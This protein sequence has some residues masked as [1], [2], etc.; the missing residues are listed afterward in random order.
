MIWRADSYS[1]TVI[2]TPG[3]TRCRLVETTQL[4]GD[5]GWRWGRKRAVRFAAHM[6]DQRMLVSG[7]PSHRF[8]VQEM[9]WG[10][11]RIIALQNRLEPLPGED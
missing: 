1:G 10:R 8:A 7:A 4:V 3:G 2:V 5:A 9:G 11:W 6:N